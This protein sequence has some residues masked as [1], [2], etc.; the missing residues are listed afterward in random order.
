[1]FEMDKT[2]FGK[3][4]AEQR[5]S[6]GYTQKMLAEKLYVSDKAVSKWERGLSMPDISLLVPL[7]EILEVS[8]TEL[9]EGRKLD[10]A[11][12]M[13]ADHVTAWSRGGATT[14]DNCQ[15]LCKTHNRAKG[16]K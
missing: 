6:K 11:S 13:D 2:S 12:E 8:V 3:F 10:C 7:S 4:L 5:K 9:L 16:N 14:I 1:M 15:M